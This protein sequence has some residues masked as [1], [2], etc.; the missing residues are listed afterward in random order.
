MKKD[1]KLGIIERFCE[2]VKILI[3]NDLAKEENKLLKFGFT[4]SLFTINEIL[5]KIRLIKGMTDEEVSKIG[6]GYRKSLSTK[7]EEILSE[8]TDPEA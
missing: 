4:G 5:E 8:D 6:E 1:N 7:D 3:S 2:H